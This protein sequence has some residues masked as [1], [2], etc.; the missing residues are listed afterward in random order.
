[1]SAIGR[2]FHRMNLANAIT[3]VRILCSA[4]FL[5]CN[6][7]S[8]TF[9]A[10]Y[11]IAGVSDIA[12]GWVARRTNTASE[13]GSK[14]DTAA[15]AVFVIVCLIKL[16]P[17]ID[18]P[19]WLI[20]WTGAIACI[21]IFNIVSVYAEKRQFAAVHSAMNKAAGALLFALPLTLSA[22]DIKY[23]A[24]IVCA[25]ATF[26]AIDEIRRIKKNFKLD[27]TFRWVDLL[28]W[29]TGSRNR[30]LTIKNLRKCKIYFNF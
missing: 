30:S 25:T 23:S 17:A 20:V 1:M 8:P 26:A 14:F 13:F 5:F 28:L 24:P 11:V 6:A 16:I 10:L 22:I 3:T 27:V 9:F 12:D 18:I 2:R 4:A 15:D 19:V 21:K 7:L 29:R